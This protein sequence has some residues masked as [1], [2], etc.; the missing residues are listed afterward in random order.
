MKNSEVATLC[1]ENN[2]SMH[3]LIVQTFL[4]RL[5]YRQEY[6]IR[7]LYGMNSISRGFAL[8]RRQTRTLLRELEAGGLVYFRQYAGRA[9]RTV[10]ISQRGVRFLE[11]VGHHVR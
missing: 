6:N 4:S 5:E 7:R 1:P 9:I 2:L 11:E 3:R 10:C 8:T